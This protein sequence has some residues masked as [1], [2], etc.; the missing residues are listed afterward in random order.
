MTMVLSEFLD[1]VL[2]VFKGIIE[3]LQYTHIGPFTLEN[4]L[5]ALLLLTIIVRVIVVRLGGAS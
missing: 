1:F 5:V 2:T 4:I 3:I